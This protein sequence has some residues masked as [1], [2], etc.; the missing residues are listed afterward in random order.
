MC[1]ASYIKLSAY[2]G[3]MRENGK[4]KK[5]NNRR[6]GIAFLRHSGV[7]RNPVRVISGQT[8]GSIY[9]GK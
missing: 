6:S 9:L 1:E 2:F 8:T 7:R 5:S 4:R 3:L